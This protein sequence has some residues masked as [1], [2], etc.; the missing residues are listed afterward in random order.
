MVNVAPEANCP[1]LGVVVPCW[2]LL[3]DGEDEEEQAASARD[4][5]AAKAMPASRFMR[6]SGQPS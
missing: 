3:L 2:V 5:A 6:T 4:A 1:A